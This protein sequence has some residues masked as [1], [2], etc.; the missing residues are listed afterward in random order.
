M[1]ADQVTTI[2]SHISPAMMSG[3]SSAASQAKE[4]PKKAAGIDLFS[5]L[6]KN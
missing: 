1:S 4:E 5:A 6:F 3:V 2:L